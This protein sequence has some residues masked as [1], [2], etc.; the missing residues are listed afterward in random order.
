MYCVN[1]GQR[2]QDNASFCSI[3]GTPITGTLAHQNFQ[4]PVF[5]NV[6]QSYPRRTVDNN[7]TQ[8]YGLLLSIFILGMLGM[9][10]GIAGLSDCKFYNKKGKAFSIFNIVFGILIDILRLVVLIV[11]IVNG[12]S[13]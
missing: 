12:Q 5:N 13:A 1:C 6:I 8:V 11:L 4:Q 3:C 10:V 9:Y 2:L 7:Q